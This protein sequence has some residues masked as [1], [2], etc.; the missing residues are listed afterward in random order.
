M[1]LTSALENAG[2]GRHSALFRDKDTNRAETGTTESAGGERSGVRIVTQ[3]DPTDNALAA[4]ASILDQPE[5][6]REPERPVAEERQVVPPPLPTEHEAP[7]SIQPDT[8]I[9]THSPIDP[10]AR[11]EAHG[12][13]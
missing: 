13:S 10:D 5:A 11:I 2:Q 7:S 1:R 9:E 4:I 6:R 8:P 12:Y 3:N